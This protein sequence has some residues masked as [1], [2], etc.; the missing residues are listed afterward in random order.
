MRKRVVL[1]V[2]AHYVMSEGKRI[3]IDP[4]ATDLPDRCKVAIAEMVT[5]SRHKIEVGS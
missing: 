1:K 2:V 3:E 5:G 4:I